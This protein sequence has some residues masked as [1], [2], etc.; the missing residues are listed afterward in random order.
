MAEDVENA[1]GDCNEPT[2]DNCGEWTNPSR[3]T[4]SLQPILERGEN[5]RKVG[6]VVNAMA[7]FTRV[8]ESFVQAIW[9]C[10]N[11][12][13]STPINEFEEDD[14]DTMKEFFVQL[15][16]AW[17]DALT[18]FAAELASAPAE[19]AKPAAAEAK[20]APANAGGR[21]KKPVKLLATGGPSGAADDD[22]DEGHPAAAGPVERPRPTM[23]LAK[24][25]FA[26][27][28][29]WRERSSKHFGPVFTDALRVLK[30][31]IMH[32]Q[33]AADGAAAPAPTGKSAG[34]GAGA[35]AGAVPAAAAAGKGAEGAKRK[36]DEAGAEAK[37]HKE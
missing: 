3:L 26:K 22:D 37:R 23:D 20:A 18:A 11:C 31:A 8:T 27:L 32:G 14:T 2:E 36:L 17:S 9:E 1:E 7:I 5:F 4:K 12:E 19:G 34:A 28:A 16:V 25:T 24:E 15:E 10:D 6:S 21:T 33:A 35:G 13:G 29:S 30:K